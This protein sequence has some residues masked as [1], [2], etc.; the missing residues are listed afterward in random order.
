[1]TPSAP[2]LLVIAKSPVAGR[3]KTRLCPPC[4][5]A[6][7]AQL[8]A[9]ALY[10]T[11]ATVI[12]VPARARRLVL[13]GAPRAWM[14]SG[15]D[16]V[17]QVG[18]GLAAR[19]AHAFAGVRGPAVLVGMDTPQVSP[20]ML[21]SAAVVLAEDDVDAILGPAPD[22]GW[23]CIGFREPEPHAFDGVAM[24]TARTFALQYER[25]RHLGMRVR[26]LPTVRD[27]D[28]ITDARAVAK[29]APASQFAAR[30]R[31]LGLAG[32]HTD[33]AR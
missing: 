14:R 6:E 28:D 26:L 16:V 18:D 19:L 10:D 11:L 9:A 17:P 5:P 22:G 32:D 23:W 13:D 21:Q 15:F 33:E 4:S 1:M 7:A 8:A 29:I 20:A 2:T 3:V 25:L 12:A 30:L 24:S 27:V 31:A